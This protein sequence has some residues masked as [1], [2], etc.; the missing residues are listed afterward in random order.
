MYQFPGLASPVDLHSTLPVKRLW[1]Y[2]HAAEGI[3]DDE[4][5]F[6]KAGHVALLLLLLLLLLPLGAGLLLP[7][8]AAAPFAGAEPA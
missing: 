8:A 4:T 6:V 5:S 2:Q 1:E 3:M 7:P